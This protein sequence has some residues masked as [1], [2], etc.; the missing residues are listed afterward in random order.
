MFSLEIVLV[1]EWPIRFSPPRRG[2]EDAVAAGAA[3][4]AS[5]VNRRVMVVVILWC[6]IILGKG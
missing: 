1:G 3:I 5:M 2:F 6:K 4:T